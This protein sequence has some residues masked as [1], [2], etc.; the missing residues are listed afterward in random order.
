VV[1]EK[2]SLE[3]AT[4]EIV[5]GLSSPDAENKAFCGE[6]TSGKTGPRISEGGDRATL[7]HEWV[8]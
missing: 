3:T 1:T 8:G 7:S 4:Q 5:R 2:E 6:V